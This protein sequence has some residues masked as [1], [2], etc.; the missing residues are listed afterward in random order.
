MWFEISSTI[1]CLSSTLAIFLPPYRFGA[2]RSHSFL[3]GRLLIS[4]P[5]AY[6]K[7]PENREAQNSKLSE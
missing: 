3:C 2:D 1:G 6:K 4:L 5:P 7:P